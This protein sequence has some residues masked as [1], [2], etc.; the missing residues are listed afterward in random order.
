MPIQTLNAHTPQLAATAWIADDAQL[1]GE[2]ELAEGASVW[3]GAQLRGD[4]AAVRIGTGSNVQDGSVL[5]AEA[6]HPVTL[7]EGVTIGHRVTL[8]GCS[9][10]DGS[11]IG[12]QAVVGRGARIGA[13]CLVGAGAQVEPGA[14]FPDGSMILG[15]PARAVRPVSAEQLEGVRRGAAHYV[16]NAR[17]YR[18]ELKRIG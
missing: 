13:R 9:V 4:G 1:I 14:E 17:R 2:V 6:G 12:I 7:G 15:A 8:D 11:L 18:A 16:D 3:F 5:R 10:G